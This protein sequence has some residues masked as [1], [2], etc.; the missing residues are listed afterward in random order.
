[1]SNQNPE[2]AENPGFRPAQADDQDTAERTIDEIA[3]GAAPGE[4]HD[5]VRLREAALL[6]LRGRVPLPDFQDPEDQSTSEDIL[7]QVGETLREG[8]ALP[9]ASETDEV[10]SS[11]ARE[12]IWA[13]V[14]AAWD[15]P[16]SPITTRSS[17]PFDAPP[18]ERP[19]MSGDRP[20]RRE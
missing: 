15:G 8:L 2:W 20:K 5:L 1:M 11:D 9:A 18:T 19:P 12:R 17:E 3:E 7:F 6:R 14:A 13:E 10:L 16:F 4:L